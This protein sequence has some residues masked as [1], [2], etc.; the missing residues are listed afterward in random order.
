MT[1]ASVQPLLESTLRA[2]FHLTTG[3]V[4]VTWYKQSGLVR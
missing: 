3:L 4:D 1:Y 2:T